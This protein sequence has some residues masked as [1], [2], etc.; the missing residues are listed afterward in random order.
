MPL[1]PTNCI[2]SESGET[3]KCMPWLQLT[4]NCTSVVHCISKCLPLVL[5]AVCGVCSACQ[6]LPSNAL[7]RRTCGSWSLTAQLWVGRV[8]KK[9]LHHR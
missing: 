5:G 2:K 6:A 9:P 8:G 3:R 7:F 1:T 4:Q